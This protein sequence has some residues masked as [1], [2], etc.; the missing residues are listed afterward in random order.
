[1]KISTCTVCWFVRCGDAVLYNLEAGHILRTKEA[2]VT[3]GG[4]SVGI[5]CLDTPALVPGREFVR[6]TTPAIS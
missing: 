1:M 5:G 6:L 2:E 3:E 4:V